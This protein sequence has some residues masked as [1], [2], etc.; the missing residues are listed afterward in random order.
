MT[1]DGGANVALII[2]RWT[3]AWRE[4]DLETHRVAMHING[5]ARGSGE[6]ARAL[7]DPM[8]VMVWLANQPSRFGRGLEAG[9][10]VSTGTCTGLDRVHPGDRVVADFGTLGRVE[11][12][13]R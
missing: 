2:G 9:D 1:A 11:V 6:G 10:I 5:E 8:A 3:A 7:G 12:M 4:L 13:V